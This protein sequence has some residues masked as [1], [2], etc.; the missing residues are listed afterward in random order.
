MGPRGLRLEGA[1]HLTG[2]N[3]RPP[4]AP[5]ILPSTT[6]PHPHPHH[7]P[8]GRK[9]Q[10]PGFCPGADFLSAREVSNVR[11]PPPRIPSGG[12]ASHFPLRKGQS[13]RP[14]EAHQGEMEEGEGPGLAT[15]LTSKDTGSPAQPVPLF[16]YSFNRHSSTCFVLGTRELALRV[17]TQDLRKRWPSNTSS[18]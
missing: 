5:Q 6:T 14:D 1:S 16:T 10:D 9:K 2:T 4:A 17:L 11:S 13:K 8:A 15:P 12:Q 3:K 18:H 7:D